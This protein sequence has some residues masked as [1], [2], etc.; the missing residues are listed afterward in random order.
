MPYDGRLGLFTITLVLLLT[1][2]TGLYTFDVDVAVP[3]THPGYESCGSL[4]PIGRGFDTTGSVN[5]AMTL[6]TVHRIQ[7]TCEE[8][9]RGRVFQLG[10]A[11][12]GLVGLLA[13]T[14]LI[15]VLR[16]GSR[17]WLFCIALLS[18][19]SAVLDGPVLPNITVAVGATIGVVFSG[20]SLL[21]TASSYS[22]PGSGAD[23]SGPVV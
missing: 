12:G 11:I 20:V 13:S 1:G 8:A 17:I 16:W 22:R 21:A 4:A 18:G 5:D 10:V 7:V 9:R 15:G 2:A 3:D 23:Q 14:V 6:L 19:G